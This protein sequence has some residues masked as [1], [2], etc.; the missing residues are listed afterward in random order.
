[1]ACGAI[2]SLPSLHLP[3]GYGYAVGINHPHRGLLRPAE[4][5]RHPKR[6]FRM[7]ATP[8]ESLLWRNDQL[9]FGLLDYLEDAHITVISGQG[10]LTGGRTTAPG[11]H[12]PKAVNNGADPPRASAGAPPAP[13]PG[14]SAVLIPGSPRPAI[15]RGEQKGW[16]HTT[17]RSLSKFFI[18]RLRAPQEGS[19]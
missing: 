8:S 19:R 9:I 11:L 16:L 6:L 5:G 7:V 15:G 13:R 18:K 14:E 12:P 1:M 4:T 17:P 3:G 10:G 2:P